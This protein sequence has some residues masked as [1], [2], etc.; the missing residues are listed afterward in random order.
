ML[1]AISAGLSN[2]PNDL[3]QSPRNIQ[4]HFL[5][6]N[7]IPFPGN[8]YPSNIPGK[9]SI[10]DNANYPKYHGVQ[11]EYAQ[12]SCLHSL[13]AQRTWFSPPPNWT[14]TTESTSDNQTSPCTNLLRPTS[15]GQYPSIPNPSQLWMTNIGIYPTYTMD[16]Q[17]MDDTL[18]W[19]PTQDQ[20]LNYTWWPLDHPKD[21]GQWQFSDGRL[22]QSRI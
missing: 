19:F 1:Q 9:S 12:S 21:L 18:T 11:Q 14:R 17:S 3:L 7:H 2:L 20:W 15:G 8:H 4:N 5:T 6:H 10:N 13:F 16:E 22:C